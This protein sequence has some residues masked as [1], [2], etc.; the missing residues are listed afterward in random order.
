VSQIIF[1]QGYVLRPNPRLIS[2][3]LY[4]MTNNSQLRKHIFDK[5]QQLAEADQMHAAENI[6][7]KVLRLPRVRRARH[8]A[9]Y[10]PVRG[11]ADPR[12]ILHEALN[13]QQ[14]CYLPVLHPRKFNSLWFMR[15]QRGDALMENRYGILEPKM[16]HQHR[17]PAHKMDVIIMPIVA[18]DAQCHRLGTG[19]GFYDRTLQFLQQRSH[20]HKPYLI[21][22]AYD[23]QCVPHI[24]KQSHDIAPHIIITETNHYRR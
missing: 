11:E 6:A 14:Y 8:I 16:D 4:S 2:L 22:I 19:G 20:Y 10:L 23:F 24:E 17:L 7:Y 13:H 12:I 15:Y 5:R 21:G 9:F 1:T 18:F 3:R